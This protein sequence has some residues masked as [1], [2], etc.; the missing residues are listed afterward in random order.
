VIPYRKF[1]GLS[2]PAF[3]K[4]IATKSLLIYPQLKELGEELD[5]IL[6]EG[7]IGVITGEMGMGKTTALRRYFESLGER[8]CHLCYVGASRHP[9]AVLQGILD[10]LG[11][12]PARLRADMLRQIGQRVDR[13]FQ[14]QRKKMLLVVDEAHLLDDNLLEDLRLLTNFEM[15]TREPLVLVLVGHPSLRKRL[16][17]PVHQALGDR[18][19]MSYRLEGLSLQ[20]TSDY[21]DCHLK[22][23]GGKPAVFTPDA[24]EAIFEL[25]QG[26]PRQINT[27]ALNCLKKSTQRKISPI[28]GG[29]VRSHPVVIQE[30][31]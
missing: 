21:I 13:M 4:S 23:A 8:S 27:L 12:A 31:R 1:H 26:I 28:D 2:G 18:V 7:G 22:Y 9:S 20:E 30:D 15:D 6:E 3:G 10:T 19:R 24:R 16:R 14:E 5:C 29:F 17:H 11:V 25:A